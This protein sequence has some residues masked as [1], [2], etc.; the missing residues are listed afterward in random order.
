MA[1][2]ASRI[3]GVVRTC[4]QTLPSATV[5][6]SSASVSTRQ[7]IVSIRQHL[8]NDLRNVAFRPRRKRRV[9]QIAC[10]ASRIDGVVRTCAQTLPSAT[11][12]K[13]SASVSTRQQIVSIRQHPLHDLRAPPAGSTALFAPAQSH[14]YYRPI[15]GSKG[16][17]PNQ[18]YS[19]REKYYDRPITMSAPAR[20]HHR[21]HPSA[22][23]QHPSANLQHPSTNHQHPSANRQHPSANRQHPLPCNYLRILV[24][25]VI[26]DS[27]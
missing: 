10:A 3:D 8:L 19:S 17:H 23:H 20:A 15:R 2:A 9:V 1:C 13:S 12:S 16:K 7:Q 14:V 5:S 22:D 25:L 21:Q 26:Y 27:G 11:V 4:A 6:K 18:T 24:Y